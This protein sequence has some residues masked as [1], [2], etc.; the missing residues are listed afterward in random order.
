M[1]HSH[2]APVSCSSP[3]TCLPTQSGPTYSHPAVQICS[4]SA[5]TC[6][7][8]NARSRVQLRYIC[9]ELA[10]KLGC[11]TSTDTHS[12]R[13]KADWAV[14]EQRKSR[15][16]LTTAGGSG[17]GAEHRPRQRCRCRAPAA[18]LGPVAALEIARSSGTDIGGRRQAGSGAA[19]GTVYAAGHR[20]RRRLL[21][22]ISTRGSGTVIVALRMLCPTPLISIHCSLID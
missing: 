21:M 1:G 14:A 7:L 2:I 16:H 15:A 19:V 3:G 17:T 10:E 11:H 5:S 6:K 18:S 13:C 20:P 22:N 4:A 9:V 8:Q 12:R